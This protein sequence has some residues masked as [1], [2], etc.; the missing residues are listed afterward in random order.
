KKGTIKK[1]DLSEYSNPR[2]S[3]IWAIS[4][5]EGDELLTCRMVR[6]E[7]QVMIFTRDGMAVRFPEAEV[8]GMGRTARGVRG[9]T[10]KDSEDHVVAMEAVDGTESVLIVCEQGYGKRS[11]V[12]EFRLTKRGGKG[13]RSIIVNERNGPV[14]GALCVTDEDSVLMM[15]HLGQTVRIPMSD[16]RVMGRSTQGVRLAN[17]KADDDKLVSVQI[18]HPESE[19]ED[20]EAAEG[21]ISDA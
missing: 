13:V 17:L 14:V 6:K 3:G 9:V 7:Q 20:G 5:D 19:G 18:V 11:A 1:T 8:R 4:I 10:L 2:R 12:E 21:P 16:V 15:S